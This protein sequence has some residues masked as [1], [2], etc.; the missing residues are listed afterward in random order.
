[1]PNP[2]PTSDSPTA[3]IVNEQ[4]EYM[5]AT[6]VRPPP[7]FQRGQGMYLWDTE[8]RKYLDFTGG[9]AVNALGHC[10]A[11]VAQI[12]HDQVSY[13]TLFFFICDKY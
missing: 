13:I 1:L 8:G 4:L 7:L 12:I 2:D 11:D 9:I 5:V 3:R 6:Y 10:D